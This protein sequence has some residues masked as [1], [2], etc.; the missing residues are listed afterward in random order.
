MT[1]LKCL[2]HG[3]VTEVTQGW[4]I[5]KKSDFRYFHGFPI[6]MIL[7]SLSLLCLENINS[8]QP[9]ILFFFGQDAEVS[10]LAIEII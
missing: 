7:N 3:M 5:K 10:P 6:K 9:K 8:V 2:T 4:F 1:L